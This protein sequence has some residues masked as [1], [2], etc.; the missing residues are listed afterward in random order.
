MVFHFVLNF[1]IHHSNP[2][3]LE[4]KK[5]K[6]TEKHVHKEKKEVPDQDL[7]YKKQKAV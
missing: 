5:P 6:M 3:H 7:E 4:K 2:K 1:E